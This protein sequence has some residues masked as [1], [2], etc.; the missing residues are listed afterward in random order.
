MC[1]DTAMPQRLALIVTALLAFVPLAAADEPLHSTSDI[2]TAIERA[3]PLIEAGAAGSA[4]QRTCFT[5][6]NQAV[7]ILALAEAKR[8]GF[9]IAAP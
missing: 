4:E 2:R 6:H 7:P 5:C 1:Y 9:A 8:R 3:I